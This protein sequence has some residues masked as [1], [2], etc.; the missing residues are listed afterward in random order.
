MDKIISKISV[1][2]IIFIPIIMMLIK[3]FG[4]NDYIYIWYILFVMISIISLI[5]GVFTF[6]Y[7]KKKINSVFILL[8]SGALLCFLAMILSSNIVNSF[9]GS[10]YRHSGF[11][12]YLCFIGLFLNCIN[13]DKKDL[14]KIGITFLIISTIISIISLLN[15]NITKSLFFYQKSFDYSYPYHGV[16]YNANHYGY[17]LTLVVILSIGMFLIEKKNTYKLLFLLIY[18]INLYT[19][20]INNTF[21][22]YIGVLIGL[23]VFVILAFKKVNKF[24]L[25]IIILLFVLNSL[26]IQYKNNVIVIDNFKNLFIDVRDTVDGTQVSAGTGRVTLWKDYCGYISKS[27]L[28]GYGGENI[29]KSICRCNYLD[30]PHNSLIELAAY[31]GIFVPIIYLLF[32]IGLLIRFIKSKKDILCIC[33]FSCCLSY[34]ISSLFGVI[35]YYTS[36]YYVIMLSVLYTLLYKSAGIKTN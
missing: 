30:A 26:T 4:I 9:L 6:F 35:I 1:Y 18:Y 13:L 24:E 27:P 25:G 8:L 7:K 12:T 32:L 16:F 21:G 33:I 29:D 23:I 14:K 20:I 11:L 22:A 3:L 36:E 28:L 10:E 2:F 19:L 5:S 34:F 15:N 31:N 17:Y